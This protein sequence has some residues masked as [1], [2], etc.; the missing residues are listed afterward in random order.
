MHF[1]K[2]KCAFY[3]KTNVHFILKNAI[4][5]LFLKN[6]SH[7]KMVISFM[8]NNSYLSMVEVEGIAF[9]ALY[10]T[11]VLIILCKAEDSCLFIGLPNEIYKKAQDIVIQI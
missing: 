8:L 4:L 6:G 9:Y 2:K 11:R 1:I 5:R 3:F 10:K 7:S